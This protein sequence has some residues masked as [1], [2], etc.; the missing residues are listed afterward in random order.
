M[1]TVHTLYRP[2]QGWS[3]SLPAS[4]DGPDTL[5]LA[6][7]A[8]ALI[9]DSGPLD[10]LVAA[11][12]RSVV[13]GCSSA[14]E[15]AAGEVGD[16][17]ISVVVT[18]FDST[19]LHRASTPLTEAGDSE[20]AGAR[21]AA[22]LPREGLRAVFMLA[23]GVAVNGT[24]LARGIGSALPEGVVVS[25]GLAGDGSLFQRTW[26]LEQGKPNEHCVTAVGLYGEGLQVGHG[27][28]GGW[29]EFGPERVITRSDGNVLYELDGQP[30]LA[31]YK[32]YLG[33]LVGQLP[34][35]A[36]RFPLSVRAARN[37]SA[38]VVRTI[39]GIDE[40]AQSMTFAGDVPQ[41]AIAQLMRTSTERL[42]ASADQAADRAMTEVGA[43]DRRNSGP[44]L[45][46]SVSCIGRRLVMGERT[47]EEVEAVV[48]RLPA[49]SAHA[50]FYSYGEI[51]PSNGCTLADLHNQTMTLTVF[52]EN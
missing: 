27:C 42:V 36:L 46:V 17:G 52:A 6:F 38:P 21:L 15:I 8:R 37:G 19:R 25:G 47:E 48:D 28:L 13:M 10:A 44:V 30:A 45:A 20:G 31:L 4:L 14:G 50:G 3:Q 23:N 35:S 41:G 40:A 39:L 22:A 2:K 18:R 29:T 7:G 12:P 32:N 49:G 33:D 16:D 34:G 1:Q 24:A 5:V 11:F 9:D 51:A 43:S 26:V